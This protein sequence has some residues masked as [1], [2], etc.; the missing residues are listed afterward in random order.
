M[1]KLRYYSKQS[2][3]W[4]YLSCFLSSSNEVD[5]LPFTLHGMFSI[6]IGRIS[7]AVTHL[8]Q[9][10]HFSQFCIILGKKYPVQFYLEMNK[11]V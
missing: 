1:P 4:K 8:Q 2:K 9:T 5:Q 6:V 11:I 10:T 3:H 7:V